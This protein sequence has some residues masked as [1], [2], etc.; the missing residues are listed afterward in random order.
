MRLTS[1]GPALYRQE[2]VGLH[3]EQFR[4]WKFRSMR[5]GSDKAVAELMPRT[6]ATVRSTRC[7]WTR[8]LPPFGRL[9]RRW[10][11]DELPQLI[12][13]L[14]GEMSLIGP[15]P[16]VQAEVDQYAPEHHRRLTVKPGITGLWQV[17]GRSDVP[18]QEALLLDLHLRRHL[19]TAS[20][21]A[22]PAE[23]RQGR[24][25]SARC[26]LAHCLLRAV[27]LAWPNNREAD[28]QMALANIRICRNDALLLVPMR[29]A[30]CASR[31]GYRSLG[32]TAVG[33]M[34]MR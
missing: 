21:S 26:V 15:R 31:A 27:P 23:D 9:L 25:N 6:A 11:I 5:C 24:R 34:M 3:G 29:T 12:N 19:V 13:V 32:S 10:S 16:Q 20:R 18:R 33:G 22:H 14:K 2:R 28:R 4:V 17:S 7:A 1:R 30:V 8:G